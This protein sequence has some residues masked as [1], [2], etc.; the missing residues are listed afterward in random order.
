[1]DEK[2]VRDEA[3]FQLRS[4]NKEGIAILDMF[5]SAAILAERDAARAAM[6]DVLEY[7][8]DLPWTEATH[9][10]QAR[11]RAALGDES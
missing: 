6:R 5:E 1:M 7:I 11:L 8:D 4:A 2:Q 9:Q 3:L 10:I